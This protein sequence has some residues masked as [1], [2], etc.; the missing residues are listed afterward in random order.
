MKKLGLLDSAWLMMDRP[1]TPMHVGILLRFTPPGDAPPDYI[2]RVVASLRASTSAESPWDLILPMQRLRGL[3]PLWLHECYLDMEHHVR[4]HPLEPGDTGGAFDRLRTLLAELH[5]QQLDRS[6]PLW[7]CHVITGLPDGEFA[8]F[9]KVHHALLDGVAGLRLM[10]SLLAHSP[11]E[12]DQPAPWSPHPTAAQSRRAAT[13]VTDSS[14]HTQQAGIMPVLGRA[15]REL[16][17]AAISHADQL[18]AP[19]RA[20]ASPFNRP[21]TARRTYAQARCEMVRIKRLS[22]LAEVSSND[23]VLAICAGALAQL[24]EDM[25]AREA[26]LTAAV[27]VSTR[28]RHGQRHGTSL[29]FCLANLGTDIRDPRTRL[30][31]IHASTQRAKEHLGRLPRAA[32]LPYTAAL[33]LPFIAEQLSPYSGR[34]RPMFNLVISNVPGPKM[35]LYLEGARLESVYPSSVLFHGQALNITCLRYRDQFSFGFTGCPDVVPDMAILPQYAMQSL[36]TLERV[37]S[38]P[39]RVAGQREQGASLL[40]TPGRLAPASP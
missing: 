19:Y 33:M 14:A 2:E 34:L 11:D 31:A 4:L 9:I 18:V 29:G 10:Q 24:L 22:K 1:E 39:H 37:F 38:F 15:A 36:E 12:R 16:A 27:P 13:R 5:A 40:V 20:P 26:P 35:P 25:D 23:V 7:E 8:L 6:R 17:R 21:I 28:P 3:V 32:Q 30:R